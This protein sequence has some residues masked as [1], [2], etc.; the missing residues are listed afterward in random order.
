MEEHAALHRRQLVDVG[1][2]GVAARFDSLD[3]RVELRGGHA[4]G[5]ESAVRPGRGEQAPRIA[6][7]R[8]LHLRRIELRAGE[9]EARLRG[10]PGRRP[11]PPRADACAGARARECRR[12]RRR[13][14][15]TRRRPPSR[16]PLRRKLPEVVEEE[17][18]D[19][20]RSA[21]AGEPSPPRARGPTRASPKAMPPEGTARSV[22]SIRCRRVV[23]VLPGAASR[24]TG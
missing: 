3:E 19:R 9:A 4:R 12:G 8:S 5:R 15:R 7:A 13:R 22:S 17:C 21:R 20:P 10:G 2:G 6:S 23:D 18:R 16:Q 11:L 24:R 1:D 14:P